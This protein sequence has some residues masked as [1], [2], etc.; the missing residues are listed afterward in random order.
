MKFLE[1]INKDLDKLA[2]AY[3]AGNAHGIPCTDNGSLTLTC[4]SELHFKE[5][6]KIDP[7]TPNLLRE[8][9]DILEKYI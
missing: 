2:N 3:A 8:I 7:R 6:I 1:K 9:A 4:L 5:R